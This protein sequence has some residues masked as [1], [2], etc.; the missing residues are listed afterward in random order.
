MDIGNSKGQMNDQFYNKDLFML[1]SLYSQNGL[2]GFDERRKTMNKLFTKI[3]G[4]ALGLTMAIGV[5]VAVA[6]NSK[7]ASP[8]EA[9]SATL[10]L[11]SGSGGTGTMTYKSTGYSG[12][13][14]G[15]S[16]KTGTAA[17][18]VA[19]GS[20]SCSF[21]A[22]GWSGKSV[23]L[24]VSTSVG[25][26]SPTT[27]SLTADTGVSGSG[28]SFTIAGTTDA[29][30]KKEFTLSNVT[31]NA[32]ISITTASSSG[33]KR[34]AIWNANYEAATTYTISYNA[35][36]GSGTMSSTTGTNPAVAACTFTAPS[37]KQ[38]SHWNTSASDNGTTYAVG[39]TPKKDLTLYA[40]WED[41]PSEPYVN[42]ALTS[43]SPAYKGS[44]VTVS[45]SSGNLEGSGLTWTVTAG[46]VTGITSSN[47]S[48]SGTLASTGTVTIKAQDN[49]GDTYDTVSVTVNAVTV[50]LDE[51]SAT[52]AQSGSLTLT[53]T[54]NTGSVTWTSNNAKVTVEA[55]SQ[56]ALKGIVSVASDATIDSTAIITATSTVDSSVHPTCTITVSEN[57]F[58]TFT[59]LTNAN[60]VSTSAVYALSN[61]GTYWAG[62]AVDSSQIASASAFADVGFFKL[63]STTGGY[64]LKYVVK[65]AQTGA[66][67]DATGNKYI[68]NG[69]STGLT[70][71]SSGSS[72]W[73]A[74][75]DGDYG[76]I[77][78][79]SSN[80]DRFLGWNGTA[81]GSSAVVR[82]YSTQN[83]HA[84]SNNAPVFLY[85]VP[86]NKLDGLTVSGQETSFTAGSTFSLGNSAVLTAH[87]SSTGNTT[88][89]SGGTVSY[90]I[91][92]VT[93]TTSTVLDHDTHDGKSVVITYTDAAGDSASTTAYTIDVDYKPAESISLNHGSAPLSIGGTVE[94]T[95]TVGDEFANPNNVSWSTSASGV[96][97]ISAASGTKTIT[98]TGV[99]AG[100]ATIT[101]TANGHS[102]TCAISV[103][104]D[105][106][107]N[108]KDS[109]DNII[110]DE[111]L[112]YF[113]GDTSVM[114]MAV[115]EN[116]ASPVYSWENDDDSVVT[117]DVADEYCE[118]TI[119]GAGTSD[120]SVTVGALTR[121]VTFSVSQSGVTSLTLT[122]SVQS[123]AL[124]DGTYNNTLTL[125]PAVTLVGNA[126][127]VINWSSSDTDVATVSSVSTT[128]PTGIT[129]TGVGAGTA[130]ITAASVY[131]PSRTATFDVTV[132]AD[133]VTALS[134]TKRPKFNSSATGFQTIWAGETTLGDLMSQNGSDGIGVFN[135]TWKSSKS[136]SPTMGTGAHNVHIG[137]YDVGAP[138]E[139]TTPLTSSYVFTTADNGKYVVAFYEGKASTN[140]TQLS[141]TKWRS[142]IESTTLTETFDYSA[143]G[144]NM[145]QSGDIT[146]AS[147]AKS[148]STTNESDSLRLGSGSATG[149]LTVTS[150][151]N[152]ISKI[153]VWVM[154]YGSDDATLNVGTENTGSISADEFERFEFTF[155]EAVSSVAMSTTASKKRVYV[156]KVV[157]TSGG[158]NQIGKTED[159]LGLETFIDT[160]LHM[161][162]YTASQ[163]WCA[164]E[165]HHYYSTAKA[166]YNSLNTH[167]K[168]LFVGNSAYTS[169]YARLRAWAAANGESFNAQNTLAA[170]SRIAPL[171]IINGSGNTVAII[172]IVSM[173]SVT[174]IG[175]YFFLRSKKE[176]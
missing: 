119:V 8:V 52:V 74:N 148:G 90:K 43:G 30:F 69:S 135:P 144:G 117:I 137:L 62:N 76:V 77:L 108:L 42:L 130:T 128:A 38:F 10:S 163:G 164:D 145:S 146:T 75:T 37:G 66:Y 129:V 95:A 49:G 126:T 39:A 134:W 80:G 106:I 150:S 15:A 109:G 47:S 34:A 88:D 55:D 104:A 122:S 64:Y 176:R 105:P 149:T 6:S 107:L 57:P 142:V 11:S 9:T 118:V 14:I 51:T 20:A 102:A 87:Y 32:T 22:A 61:E 13:K 73:T 92:N 40:I 53:A 67:E 33:D 139:E 7:E 45:A 44:T 97:S 159:C 25:T 103:T 125:T 29:D 166:A 143:G 140:N 59:K 171:S 36:T 131:T 174:A 19:S 96:A 173:I 138:T 132:T 82:A 60:Q 121:T 63:E 81:G 27:V 23:T 17:F 26:I 168:S 123:G 169:E 101:A 153:E 5:S 133:G 116:V 127:G 165:E 71:G 54:V 141:I 172:V 41:L 120:V 31:S 158:E 1:T 83:L 21:F 98:V 56:N 115:S 86:Q 124:Y 154:S 24:Q 58:A 46:S 65:N 160:Y 85:E 100:S 28:N 147:I 48:F 175:G 93:A 4:V 110:N 3:V 167:Q 84:S 16:S 50:S 114:I 18:T 111:T 113:T 151:T 91:N 70:A 94:L 12:V 2:G 72:V 157:I 152:L 162:D 99:S 156:Q 112:E 161:D 68:N 89:L 136:D 79:N 78:Q 35:N 155:D 170:S